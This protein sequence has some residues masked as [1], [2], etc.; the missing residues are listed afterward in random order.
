MPEENVSEDELIKREA[1]EEQ[2]FRKQP[3]NSKK[4][5]RSRN[6]PD[7]LDHFKKVW[8]T[9]YPPRKPHAYLERYKTQGQIDIEVER[10][11]NTHS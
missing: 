1:Q 2:K 8:K 4:E 3:P 7:D 11:F 6:R 5:G 10:W 9:L